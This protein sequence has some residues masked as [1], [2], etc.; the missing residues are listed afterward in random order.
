[1]PAVA[2]KK[3]SA[4]GLLSSQQH[5]GKKTMSA[6]AS[7]EDAEDEKV[8]LERS[9][10][11][12]QEGDQLMQKRQYVK[13]LQFYEQAKKLMP[14]GHELSSSVD[15][16]RAECYLLMNRHADAVSAA[17]DALKMNAENA[18]ALVT[19][20]KAYVSTQN[21]T[22]A[23]K[24][25]A[26][27]HALVPNDAQI[28]QLHDIIHGIGNGKTPAGLGGMLLWECTPL[29]KGRAGRGKRSEKT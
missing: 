17:S 16:N 21:E 2:V 9:V 5:P 4:A 27:A 14:K 15:A 10:E 18:Q 3:K 6:A 19:R 8:F 20:A 22:R 11:F 24:D 29:G 25:I 28:K 12:S 7:L 26:Q 13:A 1:M 23:K